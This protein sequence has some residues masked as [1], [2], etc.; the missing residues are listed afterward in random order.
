MPAPRLDLTDLR[1]FLAVAEA[2]S[3]TAGAV[4]ANL[5][6]AAASERVRGMEAELGQALLQRGRRGV[7]PTP[8]GDCLRQHARLVLQQL[9][10]L[11]GDLADHAAGQR[12]QVRL[13]CNTAA[14]SEALP[15]LLAPF[16]RA[17][18]GIDVTVEERPSRLIPRAIAAGQADLGIVADHAELLGLQALPFR[19]DRLVVAL[20]PGHRLARRRRVR[21]TELLEEDF[22][23]LAPG[24]ALQSH[25]EEQAERLGARLRVRLRLGGLEAL[26]RL[27]AAGAGLAV[28]P[29]SAAA[30]LGPG[31]RLLRLEELWAERRLLLC[32]ASLEGLPAPARR[33]LETLRLS[34][35][36]E[37]AAAF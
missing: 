24:A 34:T 7:T 14:G 33:L 5:S 8:A 21:L 32:F 28:L 30:R 23:G 11:A 3:L 22:V 27:V 25:L 18:P 6:L 12:G 13:L 4:R 10:R 35:A 1:L 20:P 19:A 17:N 9:E 16:L 37:A 2:G 26:C 31:L 29:A 36:D 15:E